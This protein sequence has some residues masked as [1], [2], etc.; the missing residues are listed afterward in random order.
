M[1]VNATS[2]N[3][4]FPS[5]GAN[6]ISKTKITLYDDNKIYEKFIKSFG[7]TIMIVLITTIP[8]IANKL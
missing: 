2:S 6:Y 3:L 5:L 1:K 4:P 7:L 8:V